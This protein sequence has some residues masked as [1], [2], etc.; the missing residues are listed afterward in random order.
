[1]G[2]SSSA[3]SNNAISLHQPTRPDTDNEAEKLVKNEARAVRFLRGAVI[4][5]LVAATTMT[6]LFAYRQEAKNQIDAF[7]RDFKG[8]APSF[9]SQFEHGLGNILCQSFTLSEAI[10]GALY[11]G[12]NPTFPQVT[13]ANLDW[14]TLSLRQQNQV[15]GVIWS[16]LL[17][18]KTERT[19]WEKYATTKQSLSLSPSTGQYQACYIC[20]E[21]FEIANPTKKLVDPAV[22]TI[23][24]QEIQQ[25]AIEGY[26]S[27][28]QC[29]HTTAQ[30]QPI[31]GCKQ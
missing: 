8:A 5:L 14:L 20:G 29:A 6:G 10:S 22:G 7:T 25:D 11:A 15:L 19:S 23:T 1:M 27:T 24:C 31:C 4:I 17:K 28:S 13:L 9:V 21:G 12:F 3:S 26:L 18:S 16:P 30:Y 2:Q